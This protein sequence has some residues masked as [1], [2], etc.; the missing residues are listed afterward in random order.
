MAELNFWRSFNTDFSYSFKQDMSKSDLLTGVDRYIT[1][2][3]SQAG[4]ENLADILWNIVYEGVPS[5]ADT[6]MPKIVNI[7]R[8][9][10]NQAGMDALADVLTAIADEGLSGTTKTE[11]L[12]L[13]QSYIEH[14]DSQSGVNGLDTILVTLINNTI[15]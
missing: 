1:Q 11:T 10:G 4:T 8:H 15:S 6:L 5:L 3:G 2:Q 14:N 7:V 12:A 9:N 13:I